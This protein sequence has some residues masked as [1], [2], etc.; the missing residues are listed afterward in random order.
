[1]QF[2]AT[3]SDDETKRRVVT[4]ASLFVEK[5][6]LLMGEHNFK[7]RFR[8]RLFIVDTKIMDLCVRHVTDCSVGRHL[9]SR[10]T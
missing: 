4:K 2:S 3:L 10:D 1:M 8:I 6:I 5:K 9:P 7:V